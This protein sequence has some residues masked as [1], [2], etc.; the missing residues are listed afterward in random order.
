MPTAS[1]AGPGQIADLKKIERAGDLA[2]SKHDYE[3][4]SRNYQSAYDMACRFGLLNDAAR[5]SGEIGQLRW[6]MHQPDLAIAALKRAVAI[7]EQAPDRAQIWLYLYN[8]GV[9]YEL[10]GDA[11]AAKKW[12]VSAIDHTNP[13]D[14]DS[15][16]H[17][18]R[19]CVNMSIQIGQYDEAQLYLARALRPYEQAKGIRRG[20]ADILT[21]AGSLYANLGQLD[22]A[23]ATYVAAEKQARLEGDLTVAAGAMLEQVLLLAETHDYTQAITK[24]NILKAYASLA[25]RQDLDAGLNLYQGLMRWMQK[26]YSGSER[27]FQLALDYESTHQREVGIDYTLSLGGMAL[28][29]Y[30][31]H[32][33]EIALSYLLKAEKLADA[34]SDIRVQ[35]LVAFMKGWVL[36]AL[37]RLPEAEKTLLPSLDL[38]EELCR[39]IG[40]TSK[41]SVM[42]QFLP[43]PYA[44]VAEVLDRNR[45]T[46]WALA[47]VERGRG[48]GLSSQL[49]RNQAM[50]GR[51]LSAQDAAELQRRND[52]VAIAG[53]RM[54]RLEDGAMSE[55]PAQKKLASGQAEKASEELR[56]A[57]LSLTSLQVN[58][59]RRYPQYQQLRGAAPTIDSLRRLI[60]SRPDTLFLEYAV[61]DEDSSLLF[62]ASCRDA[63]RVFRLPVGTTRLSALVSNWR[64]A[65]AHQGGQFPIHAIPADDV[66]MSPE[67]PTT[68]GKA[69]ESPV[70]TAATLDE[71]EIART[72]YSTLLGPVVTAGMLRNPAIRRLVIVVD[73]VLLDMPFAALENAHGERLIARY[74][75]STPVSLATLIW[76]DAPLRPIGRMLCAADPTGMSGVA[77]ATRGQ[78]GPLRGARREAEEVQ[79]MFPGSTVLLG[80]NAGK[81]KVTRLMGRF[82]LLHFATHGITDGHDG[83]RSALVLAGPH[84]PAFLEAREIMAIPLSARLAVLSA[85]STAEGQK[86]GGE[87]LLGL[88]WAF[89]AAGCPAILASQWNVNDESTTLLM[90]RFYQDLMKGR[91]KDSA[92][93]SAMLSVAA[94]PTYSSP[95]YWAPFQLIGDSRPLARE[96]IGERH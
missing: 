73:S 2:Y 16:A 75:I 60:K 96:L 69:A 36:E 35:G 30:G 23:L 68:R 33:N 11:A 27:A 3:S 32:R 39:Q 74:P 34:G 92:L 95:H 15:L 12:F 84:G 80:A 45:H 4:A 20:Y 78:F 21:S 77:V 52:A 76:P 85:C 83:M 42:L 24:A 8:L 50:V 48:L 17:S 90:R 63:L 82:A 58:L 72:L 41:F 70:P 86:S 7:A 43:H 9:V 87:G 67:S 6:Y 64:R 56:S 22:R 31:L 25:G 18:L 28:A 37:D 44:R 66:T 57:E 49:A 5:Y 46:E 19:A 10:T 13:S 81:A 38:Y 14:T 79:R 61:V 40:D 47:T 62:A 71:P 26:D 89:R 91:Q 59:G 53:N 55:D 29:N 51:L 88:A 1:P 65:I 94:N 54:R 93:R